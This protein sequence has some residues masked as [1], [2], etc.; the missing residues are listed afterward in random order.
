M[1]DAIAADVD[2]VLAL[3]PQVRNCLAA[4]RSAIPAAMRLADL[5]YPGADVSFDLKTQA[6]GGSDGDLAVILERLETMRFAAG[7][8]A[9]AD[10]HDLVVQRRMSVRQAFEEMLERTGR[11]EDID[12]ANAMRAYAATVA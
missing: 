3:E 12:R 7:D 2:A 4:I 11:D 6:R 8:Q 10:Y 5:D 9:K 1:R